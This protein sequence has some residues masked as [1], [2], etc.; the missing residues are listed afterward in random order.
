MIS[1]LPTTRARKRNRLLAGNRPSDEI[2]SLYL[3]LETC[4]AAEDLVLIPT[5]LSNVERL[6]RADFGPELSQHDLDE[7][8][9]MMVGLGARGLYVTEGLAHIRH[10]S[11]IDHLAVPEGPSSLRIECLH[12]GVL[13]VW[14]HAER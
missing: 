12:A 7:F 3:R 14:T 4:A 8:V 5:G 11:D 13:H 6:P 1:D 10:V 2:H 9:A